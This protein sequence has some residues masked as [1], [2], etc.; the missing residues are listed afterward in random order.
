MKKLITLFTF[1]LVTLFVPTIVEAQSQSQWREVTYEINM[2]SLNDPRTSDG[3]EI[4]GKE[5]TII[6]K[7]PKP[8]QVKVFTILG[9]L[10]SQ[11]LLSKGTSEFKINSRGIFIIKIGSITQ[12]IAL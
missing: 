2:Q 11:E 7:T 3:I 12:K 8:V 10:V 1:V 4:F 5:G 9:Q 6:I